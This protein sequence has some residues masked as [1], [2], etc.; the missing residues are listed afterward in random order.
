MPRPQRCRRV[1]GEPEYVLFSPEGIVDNESV[2]LSI[3]EYEVIRLVDYEKMTHEQCAQ[4][5]DVSRTTVTEIYESARF[6][7]ADSLINGKQL[8]IK[9]GKYRICS[10]EN[11]KTCGG[12][13]ARTRTPT[14]YPERPPEK[15]PGFTRVAVPFDN[16]QIFQHFGQSEQLKFFDIKD[17]EITG[18]SVISFSCM[19]HGA[20]VDF[21]AQ[22]STDILICGGIGGGAQS[23]L[24]ESG[25]R[26][27]G[28][29]SGS[30]DQA[31]VQYAL[32]QLN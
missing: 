25:I 13:C 2:Q 22:N 9:G 17:G 6:K 14:D 18:S 8:I 12:S 28:G 32:G 31:A 26:L 4:Q 7:L 20:L 15:E 16:G 27:I 23:L 24:A 3:D 29:L 11:V 5:M 10:G 1:C 21:L 30:A 19:G